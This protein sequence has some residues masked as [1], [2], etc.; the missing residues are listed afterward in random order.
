MIPQWENKVMSSLMLYVDHMICKEG[1][2]FT[3][4][5]GNFY[6]IESR[7]NGLSVYAL[8][9]KQ[10][11]GDQSL[12][13]EG[14]TLMTDV[15]VDSVLKAPGTDDFYGILYH[16]GQALF[17]TD[18]SYEVNG[19]YSVKD[20]NVYLTTELEE[21][22][23]FNTKHQVN[24][25]IN[26]ALSGL[27]EEEETYPAVFL[28][29]MGGVND[30][31]CL[32]G[33]DN[34]KTFARAVILSDSAFSLDAVCSILKNMARKEFVL[35]ENLPFNSIGAFTGVMYNY[36]SMVQSGTDFVP[37]WDVRITKLSPSDL[38]GLDKRVFAALADFEIHGYGRN[39]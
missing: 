10:I 24:P 33:T 25:R 18:T 2:A 22:L 3:N 30:P 15:Y 13:G 16:K 28:K 29:N 20:Y 36:Q 34:V 27:K 4:H 9:Y 38:K 14:A 21:S 31:L 6:P 23:L 7:Y 37:I 26:Q 39:T 5:S 19:F 17:S 11:V 8:P 35:A 1:K 12:V 32:G